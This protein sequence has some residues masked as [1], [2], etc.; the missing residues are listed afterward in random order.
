[1]QLPVALAI[2]QI[3]PPQNV[4]SPTDLTSH[5]TTEIFPASSISIG[6]VSMFSFLSFSRLGLW[7]FD[8]TTQELTQTYV[9][10]TTLASFAGTEMFFVSLFGLSQWILA[11]TISRPEQFR[12]LALVSLGTVACSTGMYASW[13]MRHRGHLMHWERLENLWPCAKTRASCG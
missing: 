1:M 10:P 13:V 9:A 8:I 7:V 3:K 12:W 4:D 2:I 5:N 11:A 6:T